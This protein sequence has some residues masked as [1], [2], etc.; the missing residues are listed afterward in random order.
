[1]KLQH[2]DYQTA[3]Y[4]RYLNTIIPLYHHAKDQPGK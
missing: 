2:K 3:Y 1:M 4:N